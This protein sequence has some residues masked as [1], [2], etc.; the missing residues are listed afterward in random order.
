MVI[1]KIE[2]HNQHSVFAD[3]NLLS[4][5]DFKV[6]AP[7]N[8]IST[9]QQK[10]YY[11]LYLSLTGSGQIIFN[12]GEKILLAEN[13]I[14]FS[15]INSV[16]AVE[17]VKDN[18]H[19]HAYYFQSSGVDLILNEKLEIDL[20]DE[21]DFIQNTATLLKTGEL[22]DIFLANCNF[23]KRIADILIIFD[24]AQKIKPI[25]SSSIA[26]ILQYINNNITLPLKLKTIAKKFGYSE[27][28]LRSI[29]LQSTG[30]LPKQYID[31]NKLKKA[32]ELLDTTNYTIE[33][34]S[35]HLGYSAPSIFMCCFK[36]KYNMTPTEYRLHIKQI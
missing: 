34:I 30:V 7:N 3:V 4:V 10:D 20:I 15:K 18:W 9:N 23:L 21:E 36:R 35:F 27:K 12:N 6:K 25:F 28:Q 26:D 33:Y 32:C 11:C 31:E 29:F 19:Y 24:K 1:E 13:E 22:F 16:R 5:Y 14:I 8:F 17:C 2:H